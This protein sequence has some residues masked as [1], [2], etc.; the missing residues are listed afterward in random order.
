VSVRLDVARSRI[1]AR[2]GRGRLRVARRLSGETRILLAR[3]LRYVKVKPLDAPHAVPVTGGTSPRTGTVP[4]DGPPTGSPS[5]PEQPAGSDAVVGPRLFAVD[6][7]WKRPL[8]ADAEL[9]PTS[10]TLVRT[11]R[12]TVAETDAWITAKA[13]SPLYPVPANQP[14]VRVQLDDNT[15]WW[16]QSLQQAFAAVPI[17]DDA[18][19]SGIS[20][21]HLTIW[22][23]ATDRLWEFFHARKL[24]DGWHA[25]WG[26]AI[27]HVSRSPGYYDERSWPG[28]SGP[29]WGATATS[30][31]VIAGTMMVDELKAGNIPHALALDIPWAK[32][33]L[34]AW[35]AQRSDGKSTDPNAIPEGARFR[36]D[37]RL[38]I[39]KL[40]LPPLVRTIAKATQR[41]GMIVRDQTGQ[42]VSLFAENTAQYGTNPYPGLF[43]STPSNVLMRAF[44]WQHLQLLKMRLEPPRV[45]RRPG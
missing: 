21:T 1:I 25:G 19:P 8:A 42:G 6:S 5:G 20:D 16:R 27:A 29:H 11:L 28:L 4:P 36:L 7:V 10:E 26:G 31:P 24:A 14:T 38:N 41:Y 40:N 13:S 44:P 34:Y 43:G 33:K 12:A 22:Q 45:S 2:A 37:P 17:P 30:L 3:R 23:P 15:Q 18:A 39:D 35:P 9:D 32:P